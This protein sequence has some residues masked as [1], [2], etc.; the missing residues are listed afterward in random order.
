[1]LGFGRKFSELINN[2][3]RDGE[4]KPSDAD[5][6]VNPHDVMSELAY[7]KNCAPAIIVAESMNA[8]C[9]EALEHNVPED[10]RTPI[11][12]RYREML[13]SAVPVFEAY[14]EKCVAH[15]YAYP[16]NERRKAETVAGIESM[17]CIRLITEIKHSISTDWAKARDEAV[18][19]AVRSV[20]LE[21]LAT[22]AR[23]EAVRMS[24]DDDGDSG[25]SNLEEE[26]YATMAVSPEMEALRKERNRKADEA[27][28]QG[29]EMAAKV[30]SLTLEDLYGE[31]AADFGKW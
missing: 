15:P 31:G 23:D 14:V 25:E 4:T 22:K 27:Y 26:S 3:K 19:R 1:M 9:D 8:L 17:N 29:Q 5:A 24:S 12:E 6:F 7:K 11:H 16:E 20:R 21:Q 18:R 10:M 28:M 30:A 2:T 13:G